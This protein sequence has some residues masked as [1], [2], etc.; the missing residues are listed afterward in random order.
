MSVFLHEE[1]LPDGVLEGTSAL[2]VDTETTSLDEMQAE[3]VGLSFSTEPGVACYIPLTH[4][5]QGAPDQLLQRT[6]MYN[7]L[8]NSPFSVVGA[9][10]LHVYRAIQQGL[11]AGAGA[12]DVGLLLI[13]K[14]TPRDHPWAFS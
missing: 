9:D 13:A 12:L 5:Y 8:I 14:K 6:T 4:D 7:R 1:D 11:H 2:A 3:I 10:D